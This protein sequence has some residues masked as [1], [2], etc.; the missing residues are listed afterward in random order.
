MK[1]ATLDNMPAAYQDA[2]RSLNGDYHGELAA[3]DG[4][5]SAMHAALPQLL[6]FL[7]S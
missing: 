6:R 2:D 1:S 3:S 4:D 5:L 7:D